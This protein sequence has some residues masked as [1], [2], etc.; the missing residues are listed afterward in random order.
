MPVT[1]KWFSKDN[2]NTKKVKENPPLSSRLS[3][4]SSS[5]PLILT[6]RTQQK[7]DRF[8]R[9]RHIRDMKRQFEKIKKLKKENKQCAICLDLNV[10]YVLS[11]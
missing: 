11:L 3:S 10:Q 6:A 2:K 1:M 8:T 7:V 9:D 5:S 4:R